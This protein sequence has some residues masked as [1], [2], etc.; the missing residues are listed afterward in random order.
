MGSPGSLA[1]PDEHLISSTFR[2]LD[3]DLRG[4]RKN[5]A[6]MNVSGP[7]AMAYGASPD[8]SA[9]G[10]APGVS[11]VDFV[12]DHFKSKIHPHWAQFPPV[13][14]MWH[15]VLGFIYIIL[16]IMCCGGNAAVM[17][18]YTKASYLKTP[19]NLLVINLALSDFIMMFTNGPPFIYNC[20]QG[21]RW[22]FSTLNCE[23]FAA[24]G[25]VTGVCSIW[26]L[27]FISFDRY[28]L[29]C[30]G[31]NGPKMTQGRAMMFMF[32][33]WAYALAGPC[34]LSSAGAPISQ[35]ASLTLAATTTSHR[36][37]RPRPTSSASFLSTSAF[38]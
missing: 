19:A 2:C 24:F 13:N 37:Y 29:I 10:Y 18:L 28:N 16:T 33:A 12:P 4:G 20:F 11:L 8:D 22:M 15:Y 32:F 7:I 3:T 38:L 17:Y 14:P 25:A 1:A 36:T 9:Y 23:L 30:N 26:T 35:R 6:T 27:A 21:G 34:L 5:F 31:F